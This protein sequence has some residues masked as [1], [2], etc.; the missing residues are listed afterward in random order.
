MA[1]ITVG[2]G[3]THATIGAAVSAASHGDDIHVYPGV[4]QEQVNLNVRANLFGFDGSGAKITGP[5]TSGS[6]TTHPVIKGSSSRKGIKL[7]NLGGADGGTELTIQGFEVVGCGYAGIEVLWGPGADINYCTVLSC[8]TVVNSPG[9][10]ALA[11]SEDNRKTVESC[12]VSGSGNTDYYLGGYGKTFINAENCIGVNTRTGNAIFYAQYGDYAS[13]S[14]CTAVINHKMADLSSTTAIIKITNG[15]V[16]NCVAVKNRANSNPSYGIDT[17]ASAGLVSN[18]WTSGS[19]G[20][21]A[22]RSG[23]TSSNVSVTSGNNS[24]LF[25]SLDDH[26]STPIATDFKWCEDA[27]SAADCSSPL[28]GI[29]LAIAGITTDY[30]GTTRANPPAVGA[31]DFATPSAPPLWGPAEEAEEVIQAA[32]A[33]G[34]YHNFDAGSHGWIIDNYNEYSKQYITKNSEN[35]P[36]HNP[37]E[38]I[39]FSLG[40]RTIKNLRGHEKA[41]VVSSKGNDPSDM[42]KEK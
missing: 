20:T 23:N 38:Q 33:G 28:K 7:L 34:G 3:K 35:M 22:V 32:D 13:A 40:V 39:P 4:Y 29:G 37:V 18:C 41:Y 24:A 2:S 12:F 19:W 31:Y 1:T 26:P 17:G 8:G 21:A 42:S 15:T 9:I 36:N 14:F 27:A 11:D 16:K 10:I 30:A 25:E 5:I 6:H